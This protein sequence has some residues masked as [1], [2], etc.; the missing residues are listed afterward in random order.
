MSNGY[1]YLLV[2][3]GGDVFKVGIS[4]VPTS[5]LQKHT[6]QDFIVAEGTLYKLPSIEAARHI[7]LLILRSLQ[8][9]RGKGASRITDGHTECFRIGYLRLV[10][11]LLHAALES[12]LGK[13]YEVCDIEGHSKVPTRMNGWDIPEVRAARLDSPQCRVNGVIYK[14]F[15]NAWIELFGEATPGRQTARIKWKKAG[16]LEIRGLFFER[17]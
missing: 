8:N 14:S 1:L 12:P 6:R 7:E 5:R 13:G 3:S 9:A 16:Q 11:N 2:H 10:S 15:R 4:K 17:I